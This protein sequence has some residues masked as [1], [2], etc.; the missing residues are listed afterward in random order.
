MKLN[1]RPEIDGLRAVAVLSVIFYHAEFNFAGMYPFKGGFFGVDIFFV[2]SGYLITSLILKELY[3][4]GSFS[5]INFFERRARR[6]LPVLYLVILVS[7]FFAYNFLL[8][9]DF[10]GYKNSIYSAIGF[11]SN[12]YFYNEELEYFNQKNLLKPF[13]HTWSLAVEE[14]FY[15]LFP[16]FLVLTFRF[17]KQYIFFIMVV[18][19]F[20]SF[21]MAN[22]WVYDYPQSTFYLLPTRVWE[23]M[24]GSIIA[25]FELKNEKPLVIGILNKTMPIL[26]FLL[27]TFAIVF[28]PD[29]IPHPSF[30]TLPPIIGTC[31]VIW[32]AKKKDWV[33]DLLSS[34]IFVGIGLVSYSL[35]LWHYPI[36]AFARIQEHNLNYLPTLL[37]VLLLILSFSIVSYFFIEQYY[38]N[39]ARVSRRHLLLFLISLIVTILLLFEYS[40]KYPSTTIKYFKYDSSPWNKL[41]GEDGK[42]CYERMTNFCSFGAKHHKKIFLIGD[43]QIASLQFDL[44]KKLKKLDY[45][46]F[47]LTSGA[48]YYAPD[49]DVIDSKSKPDAR[50]TSQYQKKRK[51][52]ILKNPGSF[53]VIGGNLP[54]YLSKKYFDNQME[55]TRVELYDRD[56]IHINK[57]KIFKDMIKPSIL[58]ILNSGSYVIIIYPIPEPGSH[59]PKKLKILKNSDLTWTETFDKT[60]IKRELFDKRVSEVT[61]LYDSIKHQNLIRIYPHEVI[62]N[63]DVCKTHD[64]ENIFY[65]DT[66]HPSEYFSKI[67]ND[68]IV[69]S[70]QNKIKIN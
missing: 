67:I 17:I 34:N 55:E 18:V 3:L 5:F 35:Y 54:V 12:I 49:F 8:E 15:I 24:A 51:D 47:T 45:Q 2:I 20:I 22:L 7:F 42:R 26:G 57:N 58:E 23:L 43:S 60:Y 31:L 64:N 61:K 66:V 32:F 46:Y 53:V 27:I 33:T 52:L 1:Y 70:I 63:N 25:Y 10:N 69:R 40:Y 62:C 48:C 37:T 13:L 11:I 44:M 4:T 39:N 14:Q 68:K 50:C 19:F 28:T 30:Y 6:I 36:L 38:R 65:I 41:K 16:I 59:I 29:T 9:G 56:F 21:L